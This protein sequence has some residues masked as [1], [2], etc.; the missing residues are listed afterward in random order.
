MK[1]QHLPR[2]LGVHVMM[3]LVDDRGLAREP[4]KLRLA[5]RIVFACGEAYGLVG[6]RIADTHMHVL[7]ATTRE[8]AGRFAQRVGAS[9]SQRL[10]LGA[11][12]ER[13]RF[14]AIVTES[15]LWNCLRYAMRQELHHGSDFDAAHDGSSLPDALGLRDVGAGSVVLRLR[16]LLPRLVPADLLDWAG[17]PSFEEVE[18][19]LDLL[20]DAAAA[21]FGLPRLEGRSDDVAR[22][23]LAAAHATTLTPR[24]LAPLLSVSQ[25]AVQRLRK[26]PAAP[27]DVRAV[28]LQ[29]R[30][31]TALRTRSTP[32]DPK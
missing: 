14:K 6:F 7:L 5:A 25:R 10:T 9:L 18:P 3:R 17:Y 19:C 2:A 12:F 15:H 16:R 20:P 13:S 28:R 31:R 11:S 21:A 23:R 22:A 24:T 8:R 27:E 30:L 29:H 32:W 4:A 26:L 1:T